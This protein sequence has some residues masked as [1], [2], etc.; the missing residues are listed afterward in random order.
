M[1]KKY[2]EWVL[3]YRIEEVEMDV[4]FIVTK[5][6]W[7]KVIT[8]KYGKDVIDNTNEDNFNGVGFYDFVSDGMGLV[9]LNKIED[10]MEA[11]LEE[12]EVRKNGTTITKTEEEIDPENLERIL[13]RIAYKL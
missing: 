8:E 13:L 2:I 11:G 1:L 10:I 9:F 12:V 4:R 3:K 7:E 5:E 6:D